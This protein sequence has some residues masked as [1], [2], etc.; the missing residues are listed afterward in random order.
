M[1]LKAS[2]IKYQELATDQVADDDDFQEDFSDFDDEDD[3]EVVLGQTLLLGGYDTRYLEDG[4]ELSYEE[5][6]YDEGLEF[7]E[8][9]GVFIGKTI[10]IGGASEEEAETYEDYESYEN[11]DQEFDDIE[12]LLEDEIIETE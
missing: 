9:S 8:D 5:E 1:L 2:E 7:D 6:A 10:V 12:S 4:E 11:Q 3:G